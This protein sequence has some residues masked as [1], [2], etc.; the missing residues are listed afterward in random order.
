MIRLKV[1][2]KKNFTTLN[3]LQFNSLDKPTERK[4]KNLC[5]SQNNQVKFNYIIKKQMKMKSIYD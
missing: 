5:T 4:T 3:S 2:E 1:K